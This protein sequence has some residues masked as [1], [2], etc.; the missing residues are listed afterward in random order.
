MLNAAQQQGFEA[1]RQSMAP[2]ANQQVELH[3]LWEKAP[4]YVPAH[5]GGW[6]EVPAAPAADAADGFR[7]GPLALGAAQ[8]CTSCGTR[9]P[10]RGVKSPVRGR[11][12]P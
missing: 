5:R 12:F 3:S 6:G 11:R 2:S 9:R 7:S 4:G 10:C 1:L 8:A